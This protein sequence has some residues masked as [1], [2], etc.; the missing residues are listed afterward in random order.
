MGAVDIVIICVVSVAFLAAVGV[1][2]YRKIKHKGGCDCGCESCPHN[3]NCKS[4]K[5]ENK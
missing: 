5:T 3:C 2:I 4:N 1:I